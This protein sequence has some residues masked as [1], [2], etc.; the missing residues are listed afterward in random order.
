MK[1]EKN[2][3]LI[4]LRILKR[5]SFSFFCLKLEV[6]F[7]IHQFR[8]Y[9]KPI[10]VFQFLPTTLSIFDYNSILLKTIHFLW[11]A[12]QKCLFRKEHLKGITISK[13]I[14]KSNDLWDTACIPP[15][16]NQLLDISLITSI[17]SLILNTDFFI[18][19]RW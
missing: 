6:L 19:I 11:L 3:L 13:N 4:V 18:K 2:T 5:Q 10:F 15:P 16:V 17:T 1:F 9:S 7:P 12:T 8:D 14:K